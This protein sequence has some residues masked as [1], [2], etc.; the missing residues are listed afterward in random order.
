MLATVRHSARIHCV[1]EF[2]QYAQ[3]VPRASFEL[4]RQSLREAAGHCDQARELLRRLRD[5]SE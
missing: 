1:H 4:I 2:D 5:L 3:Q